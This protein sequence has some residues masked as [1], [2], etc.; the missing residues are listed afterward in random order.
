MVLH[1]HSA[2]LHGRL[3]NFSGRL[4]GEAAAQRGLQ[5]LLVDCDLLYMSA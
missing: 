2:T 5:I 4:E 3:D 1:R